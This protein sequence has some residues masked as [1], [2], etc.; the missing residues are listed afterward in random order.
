MQDLAEYKDNYSNSVKCCFVFGE[1]IINS[2]IAII[3]HYQHH[4]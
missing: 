4:I 1:F 3:Y 2:G